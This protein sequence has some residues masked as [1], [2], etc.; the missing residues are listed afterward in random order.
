ML[1]A[2]PKRTHET[3]SIPFDGNDERAK[4]GVTANAERTGE[5][6]LKRVLEG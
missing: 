5:S 1:L 3:L 6:T 4:L 2:C